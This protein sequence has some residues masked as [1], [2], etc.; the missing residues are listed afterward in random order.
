[1]ISDKEKIGIRIFFS[2]LIIGLFIVMYLGI[3]VIWDNVD[4]H[5]LGYLL[6]LITIILHLLLIFLVLLC[7]RHFSSDEFS[8]TYKAEAIIVHLWSEQTL[9]NGTYTDF[10]LGLQIKHE[11]GSSYKTK[12]WFRTRTDY[13]DYFKIGKTI[14][15]D[16]SVNDPNK[17]LLSDD[18]FK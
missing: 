17:V 11:D 6:S 4:D 8:E 14:I 3:G 15:V 1:M 16:V 9:R 12:A 2:V 5:T 7:W 10:D 13:K 18:T